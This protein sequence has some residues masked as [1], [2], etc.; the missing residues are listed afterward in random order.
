M[1]QSLLRFTLQLSCSPCRAVSPA[2]VH[3]RRSDREQAK[4]RPGPAAVDAALQCLETL[5]CKRWR[6]EGAASTPLQRLGA[7]IEADRDWLGEHA[8]LAALR[9]MAA[10][11]GEGQGGGTEGEGRRGAEEDPGEVRCSS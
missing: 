10:L 8:R 11:L 1:L 3:P 2:S 7:V 4:A 5:F 9:V 6:A